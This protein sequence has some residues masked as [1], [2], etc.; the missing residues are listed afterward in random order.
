MRSVSVAASPSPPTVSLHLRSRAAIGW[1]LTGAWVGGGTR[2]GVVAVHAVESAAPFNPYASGGGNDDGMDV[3]MVDN[4][5]PAKL[6]VTP[7]S[8]LC[9]VYDPFVSKARGA[10]NVHV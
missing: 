10:Y 9:G 5:A 6:Q 8:S 1:A 2:Q 7:A 3:Y 4:S